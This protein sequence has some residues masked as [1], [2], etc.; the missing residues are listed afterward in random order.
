MKEEQDS[1]GKETATLVSMQQHYS[2][3]L[4]PAQEFKSY[5]E[6]LP[7]APE[8]ILAMAE[9]E[10]CHRHKKEIFALYVRTASNILGMIFG[11]AIVVACLTLAYRLGMSGHDGLAGVV[12][13]IATSCA[14]IF[15]LRKMPKKE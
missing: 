13:A 14:T 15:V 12:I 8:R 9:K 1:M 6:V 3:P 11:M 4:P 10:Q 5:G 7:S 2:G